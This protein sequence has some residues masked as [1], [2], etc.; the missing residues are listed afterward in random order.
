MKTAT[1]TSSEED[2]VEFVHEHKNCLVTQREVGV[3]TD[4]WENAL[5]NT[6]RQAPDV[7]LIGETRHK[8]TMEH[9]IAFA[10]TGHLAMTK[11]SMPTAPTRRLTASSTSFPR[12]DNNNF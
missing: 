3:D 10:E 4:S 12:I 8:E 2:P 11:I 9:A 6:L 1:D 7:I 5:H